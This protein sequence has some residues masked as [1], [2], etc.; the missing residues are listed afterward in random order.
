MWDDEDFARSPS[1]TFTY[2]NYDD[3][4]N[5]TVTIERSIHGDDTD[6]LPNLMREFLYFL[7]GMTFTYVNEIVA[8]NSDGKEISSSEDDISSAFTDEDDED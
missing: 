7:N 5:P 6:F 8:K 3:K 2:R 1:I 4:G